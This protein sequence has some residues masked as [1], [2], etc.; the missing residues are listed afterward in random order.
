[1]KCDINVGWR[2]GDE[3]LRVEREVSR[4][5][6]DV[7]GPNP[8]SHLLQAVATLDRTYAD[9]RAALISM[10]TAT[11][12]SNVTVVVQMTAEQA[13]RHVEGR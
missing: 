5:T 13:Q 6:V 8:D 3:T 7:W 2:S 1:M 4:D 9:T 12:A 10:M 11:A